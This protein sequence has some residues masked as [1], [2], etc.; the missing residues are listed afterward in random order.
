MHC[1]KTAEAKVTQLQCLSETA[2]NMSCSKCA[3]SWHRALVY[4]CSWEHTT[5]LKRMVLTVGGVDRTHGTLRRFLEDFCTST[6][7]IL[8]NIVIF[9]VCSKYCIPILIKF[10]NIT[11]T[12]NK[13]FTFD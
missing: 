10:I 7:D 3:F 11:E 2:L 9:R 5:Q 8:N 1:D 4:V 12:E 6:T 13:L